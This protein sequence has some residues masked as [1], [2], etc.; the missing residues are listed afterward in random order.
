[1]T[2]ASMSKSLLDT[3]SESFNMNELRQ[4][5]FAIGID[6]EELPK[7][8]TKSGMAM[9]LIKYAWRRDILD[10]LI[11]ECMRERPH[12]AWQQ[13]DKT[14]PEDKDAPEELKSQFH[15]S[16]G[17]ITNSQINIAGRDVTTQQANLN[18]DKTDDDKD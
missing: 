3:I 12:I 9:A 11:A 4:L 13:L 14:L 2:K 18:T 6:D 15:V 16:T 10:S 7:S 5:C 8:D 17:N 1:M